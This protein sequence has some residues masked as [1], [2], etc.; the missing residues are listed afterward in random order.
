MKIKISMKVQGWVKVL[1]FYLFTFLPLSAQQRL[2]NLRE[3]CDYA[4]ANNI[5][6]KQQENQRRQQEIKLSTSK[7]SRLPDLSGSVGQ[8]FSDQTRPA[9]P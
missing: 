3:C 1:P 9:G 5:S 6:I 2:W 8:N 4:V 7:N